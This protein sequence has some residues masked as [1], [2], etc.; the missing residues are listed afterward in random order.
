MALKISPNFVLVITN[1][2]VI[3][4]IIADKITK[5]LYAEKPN[6]Y[7]SNLILNGCYTGLASGPK[8][9][10]AN[11]CM[12]YNIP[13]VAI[14]KGEKRNSG[15]EKFY[16]KKNIELEISNNDPLRYFLQRLRDE[17]HRFVIGAHRQKRSKSLM[18]TRLDEIT[19]LGGIRR[20]NLLMR[21]GSTKEVSKASVNELQKVQG[22]SRNLAE[23]IYNFFNTN[24]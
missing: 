7:K 8:V 4:S 21:F 10:N 15:L 23:Q 22:I 14:A 3:R 16:H 13:I 9:I 24:D 20:K 6:Q 11:C 18:S 19:G 17:V 12:I 5:N 2:I 1:Q